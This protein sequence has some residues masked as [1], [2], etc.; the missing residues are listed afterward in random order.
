MPA[1]ACPKSKMAAVIS[2]GVKTGAAVVTGVVNAGCDDA[3]AVSADVT[4]VPVVAG[5]DPGG[6]DCDI[7]G[8]GGGREAGGEGLDMVVIE[9]GNADTGLIGTEFL[10][11]RGRRL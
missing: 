6:G 10:P 3:G 4:R 5:R 11:W 8:C 1:T 2:C 9:P 7:G